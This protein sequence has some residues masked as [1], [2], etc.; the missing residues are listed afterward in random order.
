MTTIEDIK[1][2]KVWGINRHLDAS[3]LNRN[4]GRSKYGAR[5]K[6]VDGIIFD[7]VAEATRYSELK[8][9]L[10]AGEIGFLKLQVPFELNPN[11]NFS[12]KYIADFTYTDSKTGK[13]IVEDKKGFKTKDYKKKKKLM[14]KVYNINISET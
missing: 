3:E 6:N 14:L 12:Y 5:K 4:R 10:K 8:T 7:S 2:S 9:L 1:K 11:G 13:T